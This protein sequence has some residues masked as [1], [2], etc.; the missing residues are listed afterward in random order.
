MMQVWKV[1][2]APGRCFML[3]V[4]CPKIV[5]SETLISHNSSNVVQIIAYLVFHYLYIKAV[6]ICGYPHTFFYL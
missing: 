5:K 1:P 6:L 2:A 3:S 4:S